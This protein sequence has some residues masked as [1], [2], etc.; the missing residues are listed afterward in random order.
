MLCSVAVADWCWRWCCSWYHIHVGI[1]RQHLSRGWM[2]AVLELSHLNAHERDLFP[3]SHIVEW[4]SSS[5]H[6]RSKDT[7]AHTHGM[8]SFSYW[9]S[10]CSVLVNDKLIW[11]NEFVIYFLLPHIL[12]GSH[13]KWRIIITSNNEV[14]KELLL[15]GELMFRKRAEKIVIIV[16]NSKGC[17]EEDTSS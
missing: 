4:W 2:E 1:T 5:N 11:V 10:S 3:F 7:R 9:R 12:T 16:T 15:F 14:S 6:I 13:I 8:V 17:E